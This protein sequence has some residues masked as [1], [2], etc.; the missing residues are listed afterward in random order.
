MLRCPAP[1]HFG[2]VETKYTILV[3]MVAT[4]TTLD[5]PPVDHLQPRLTEFR[6]IDGLTKE[7]KMRPPA[8][9]KPATKQQ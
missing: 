1:E 3:S 6:S 4:I 9:V 7:S 8:E 5:P 2:G